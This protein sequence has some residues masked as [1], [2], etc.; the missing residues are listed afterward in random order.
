[1]LLYS[2]AKRT[3]ENTFGVYCVHCTPNMQ[4]LQRESWNT[5]FLGMIADK[6]HRI[7]GENNRNGTPVQSFRRTNHK[8]VSSIMCINANVMKHCKCDFSLCIAQF[9]S[10]FIRFPNSQLCRQRTLTLR[11]IDNKYFE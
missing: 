8:I 1:M 10:I 4:Q 11:K 5:P 3:T 9:T 7:P 6:I 2:H